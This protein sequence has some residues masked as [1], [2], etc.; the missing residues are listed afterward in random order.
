MHQRQVEEIQRTLIHRFLQSKFK[1]IDFSWH[2]EN[3]NNNKFI[4][5]L[6][7][8]LIKIYSKN[9]KLTLRAWTNGSREATSLFTLSQ[10]ISSW[11]PRHLKYSHIRKWILYTPFFISWSFTP[12]CSMDTGLWLEER[13]HYKKM[14]GHLHCTMSEQQPFSFLEKGKLTNKVENLLYGNIV[15]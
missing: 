8:I 1:F 12:L 5:I 15:F 3:L 10:D 6:V 7:T 2:L 4:R 14:L 9:W 13:Q 11:H